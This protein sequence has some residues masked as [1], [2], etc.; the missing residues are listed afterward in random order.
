MLN[1]RVLAEGAAA[2]PACEQFLGRCVSSM[3]LNEACALHKGLPTFLALVGLPSAGDPLTAQRAC[4]S[5][6]SPTSQGILHRVSLR[7]IEVCKGAKIIHTHTFSLA[8]VPLTQ[9]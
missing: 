9:V 6:K 4:V 7:A 3:V 8:G 1:K 2:L 5:A